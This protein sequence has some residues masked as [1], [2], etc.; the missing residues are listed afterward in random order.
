MD[1]SRGEDL[2][3][4]YDFF[5][6]FN[7]I[8]SWKNGLITYEYSNK[9]SSGIKYSTCNKFSTSDN[10]VALVGELKTPSLPPSVR[11]LPSSPLS[12]YFYQEMKDVGEHVAISA[13]NLFQ[14]DMDLPPLPFHSS[15]EE[16]WDEEE[17]PEEIGT[18]LKV[19]PPADH[20][21]F[22]A[23]SNFK[24]K[25]PPTHC[26]CDHHIKLD[27]LLHPAKLPLT[28][29]SVPFV[30][31]ED[32]G[33]HLCVDYCKLNSVARKNRYPVPP[34]NQ[35]LTF[36]NSSAIF[37]NIDLQSAYNLLR[38]QEGHEQLTALR[39]KYGSYEY[40]VI[41]FGLT[42]A[43]A[44]FQNLVNYI[45]ADFLDNLVIVYLDD[46]M[47]FSGSEEELLKHVTS[48]LQRLRDNNFFSKASKCIFH[49]GSVE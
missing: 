33:L 26:T 41:P 14:G 34:M 49:A 42:N 28:G 29:A 7:P 11:I 5:Y 3:L 2:I 25:E 22:D 20:Q 6:H 35:L 19:V 45:F 43:T 21:Y 16:Q 44:S 8:I 23:F 40:L 1:S 38:I 24:A 47:V 46:I 13:L 10:S 18:V 15:L 12:H 4:G 27:G 37:Y 31:K 17:D 30:K 36:F 39:A 9:D 48:V 32:G